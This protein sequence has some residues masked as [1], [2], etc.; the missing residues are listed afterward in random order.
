MRVRLDIHGRPKS[1]SSLSESDDQLS[2][3]NPNTLS[4]QPQHLI[5]VTSPSKEPPPTLSSKLVST[6]IPASESSIDQH[7]QKSL[8]SQSFQLLSTIPKQE[9]EQNSY[10]SSQT[11]LAENENEPTIIPS[12][13]TELSQSTT[14]S[15]QHHNNPQSSSLPSSSTTRIVKTSTSSVTTL[16]LSTSNPEPVNRPSTPIPKKDE[17]QNDPEPIGSEEADSTTSTEAYNSEDEHAD[18]KATAAAAQPEIPMR[19]LRERETEFVTMLSSKGLRI[20]EMRAD[21]NCLFRALAH[22]VW[23]DAERHTSLRASVMQYLVQEADYFSQFVAEDFRRY[24]CRKRREGVHGNHLEL[25]AASELFGRP[26]EVYSYSATPATIID[27]YDSPTVPT[28]EVEPIRLSFHRG[29]HYNAVQPI[30]GPHNKAD[31]KRAA[32]DA[33]AAAAAVAAIDEADWLAAADAR[34]T[35]DEIERAVMALSLIEATRGDSAPGSS[36]SASAAVPSSVLAL[37]NSGYSEEQ[38]MQAYRVVGNGGLADMIRFLTTEF[39]RTR[40][41]GRAIP[42]LR[43]TLPTQRFRRRRRTDQAAASQSREQLVGRAVEETQT[44]GKDS[45]A[46]SEGLQDNCDVQTGSSQDAADSSS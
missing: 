25:Q 36:S 31:Q 39:F 43:S 37:I 35:E 12:P 26:I 44:D 3:S 22:C 11:K 34:A 2:H 18:A 5:N 29:S 8:N 32:A 10:L 30:T 7:Q 45:N 6:T 46:S 16:S 41:K 24:V 1:P 14:T 4:E 28:R 42:S 13:L 9:Q 38:A 15:N 23:G 19:T 40:G 27:P 17:S 20:I 33:S 21:G